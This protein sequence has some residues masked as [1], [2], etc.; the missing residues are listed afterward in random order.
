MKLVLS[1]TDYFKEKHILF[2]ASKLSFYL[3]EFMDTK[4]IACL[5]SIIRQKI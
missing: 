3:T 2:T 5:E 4:L 1:I